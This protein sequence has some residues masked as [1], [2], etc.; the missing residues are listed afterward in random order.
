MLRRTERFL[1][2]LMTIGMILLI[3]V[4]LM[5][6]SGEPRSYIQQLESKIRSL[7]GTEVQEVAMLNSDGF[8]TLTLLTKGYYPQARVLVNNDKAYYFTKGPVKV[9]VNH[10]DMIIFDTRGIKTNLR[11]KVLD[12]SVGITNVR[13]GQEFWVYDGCTVFPIEMN[14]TRF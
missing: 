9:P 12:Y 13:S 7:T 1:V 10:S 3:T 6:Q 5:M 2:G 8:I 11:F 4:Q 14:Q